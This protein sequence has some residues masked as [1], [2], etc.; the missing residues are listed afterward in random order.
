V[1]NLYYWLPRWLEPL[2]FK[3]L[4]DSRAAEVRFGLHARSVGPE[5][6]EMA[7]E[8]AEIKARAGMETPTLDTLLDFVTR[9][10]MDSDRKEAAS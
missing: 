1:F 2:V 7:E 8:F 10:R 5:L 6:L 3:K 4:F 9:P